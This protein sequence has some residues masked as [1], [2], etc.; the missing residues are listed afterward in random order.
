MEQQAD[1]CGGDAQYYAQRRN[2]RQFLLQQDTGKDQ[3]QAVTR[4]AHAEGEEKHEE[5]GDKHRRVK[6][7]VF[8]PTVHIGKQLKLRYKLI[9]FQ[10]DRRI[11]IHL[12]LVDQIEDIL[13]LQHIMKGWLIL[14]GSEAFEDGDVVLGS[15]LARYVCQ[16]Q[17]EFRQGLVHLCLQHRLMPL[18][19]GQAM[20]FLLHLCLQVGNL[21]LNGGIVTIGSRQFLQREVIVVGIGHNHE[22]TVSAEVRNL[23]YRILFLP[24]RIDGLSLIEM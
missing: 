5:D 17:V 10:F 4:I 23:A 16:M 20:L 11:I 9:V 13:L 24:L 2:T 19:L 3:N 22:I 18:Q 12:G 7:V 8:W 1:H 14:S 6:L 15:L 21:F